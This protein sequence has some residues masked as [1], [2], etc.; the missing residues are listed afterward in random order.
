MNETCHV[1]L[2]LFFLVLIDY[3][4][5]KFVFCFVSIYFALEVPS[6]SSVV[7]YFGIS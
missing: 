2:L 6:N 3:F 1:F 4:T 5:C 7:E